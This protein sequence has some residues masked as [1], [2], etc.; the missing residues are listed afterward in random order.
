MVK[1]FF[2]EL[3]DKVFDMSLFHELTPVER[4]YFALFSHFESVYRSKVLWWLP[5]QKHL[6][7]MSID[8]LV[9][10]SSKVDRIKEME[11]LFSRTTAKL[12]GEDLRP[13]DKPNRPLKMIM[14]YLKGSKIVMKDAMMNA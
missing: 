10:A 9:E 7:D 8:E 6:L 5:K 12:S 1:W 3:P 2:C 14:V 11:D 13:V 4:A